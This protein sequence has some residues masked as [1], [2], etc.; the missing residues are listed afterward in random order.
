MSGE[1]KPAV[2]PSKPTPS[3]EK[4]I[5]DTKNQFFQNGDPDLE[6]TS[7]FTD[8]IALFHF[9]DKAYEKVGDTGHGILRILKNETNGR[10]RLLMRNRTNFD[11]VLLHY[12][13]LPG[14]EIREK[15]LNE[16]GNVVI[17][18]NNYADPENPKTEFYWLRFASPESKT[19]F[20]EK[21]NDALNANKAILTALEN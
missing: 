8:F 14:N 4:L 13:I 19:L 18:A 1:Q 15:S 5:Q 20:I 9:V 6:E 3:K 10:Y 2:A 12:Y 17:K 16:K 7:I 11:E 21:Y